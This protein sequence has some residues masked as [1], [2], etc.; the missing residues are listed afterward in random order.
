LGDQ[1]RKEGFPRGAKGEGTS[2][3]EKRRIWGQRGGDSQ[4][5]G[6][7]KTSR[8]GYSFPTGMKR[9]HLCR[10]R[11]ERKKKV[12]AGKT[13]ERYGHQPR[14]TWQTQGAKIEMCVSLGNCT[15]ATLT[16]KLK[17]LRVL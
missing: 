1:A 5:G 10:E 12:K 13:E 3:K 4:T 2:R 11:K 16:G 17:G 8:K 6:Q 9:G 7:R 14:R 15:T